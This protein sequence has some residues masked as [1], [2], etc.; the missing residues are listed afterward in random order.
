M[1]KPSTH[2]LDRS[3]TKAIPFRTEAETKQASERKRMTIAAGF[4]CDGGILFGAD[5]SETVGDMHLRVHKIPVILR[6]TRTAW[7]CLSNS[8]KNWR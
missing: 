2:F 8:S 6:S 5:T 4:R 3:R 1:H 7:P